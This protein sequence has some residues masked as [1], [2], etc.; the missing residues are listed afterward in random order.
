MSYA[1]LKAFHAVAAA[2]GFSKAA[3]KLNLT[4]PAISDHIRKLEEAYGAELFVRQRSGVALS[5]VA[6]Q[7]YAVTERMFEAE[8]EATALLNRARQL[9]EGSLTIG[10]DAAS[11]VL[12]LIRRFREQ[13]PKI[14][15]K[16]I[17]GNSTEL[18]KKLD[19]FAIDF[20]VVG[21]RP[22]APSYTSRLLREDGIVAFVAAS[23]PLATRTE[24]ALADFLRFPIVLR[25]E[26]STT[27]TLLL[28][29]I[30]RRDTSL[31]DLIEIESREASREAVASGIGIGIIS[32]AEIVPDIRL[33][34]LR[35]S[36]WQPTMSEW[37]VCLTARL[38]L[39]IVRAV[40]ALLRR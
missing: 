35:F 22:G 29:E 27:R 34:T 12:P 33:K 37:L 19:S 4:Q 23:H 21:E 40:L 32:S 13:H 16:V 17:A 25:E 1:Q 26:G 36:D 6:R 3:E 11:H 15:M 20:A 30:A 28:D 38:D 14:A 8:S 18:L 10:A 9:E 24:I 31:T 7:L 2:G 39:Q 5:D